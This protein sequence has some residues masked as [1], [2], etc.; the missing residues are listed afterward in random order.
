MTKGN[1]KLQ[2]LQVFSGIAILCVVLI[3]NNAYYLLG[4]LKVQAYV[5]GSFIVRLL[6][7]FIHAS[8]SMF[9]FIAGYKYALNNVNDEYKKYAIKKIK[10]V[11]K[12]FIIISMIFI[13][14]NNTGSHI[15][16]INLRNMF[17]QFIDIFMGS[18]YAYQLWYV[19]MYI[20]I[21]LTYPI[22]YKLF[23]KERSRILIILLIVLVE[24]ILG[25]KFSSLSARPFN[26]V[27]YYI[28]FE[29]G[30]I[31]YK[32]DI[33]NKIVKWDIQIICAHIIAAVILTINPIPNLYDLIQYY[34]EWPLCV[35]AYYLLSFRLINNKMFNYLGKYSFYIFLFHAPVICGRISDIFY[36]LG[37][38][39][40]IM[41]VFIITGLTI[42]CTMIVYKV[43]EHTFLKNILF[44]F[45]KKKNYQLQRPETDYNE[46]I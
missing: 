18:N 2:E 4:V 14:I 21:S 6:D 41:Y 46:V 39:N 38:Y 33:K 7:N 19:P 45:D 25:R 23:R 22:I 15:Y 28:F 13:I 11:I 26:F 20:F 29:M 40:S 30:L 9:I 12:P 43:I 16:L 35:T 44:T 10:R 36:D 27:Y 1:D 31:F 24:E 8:V 3:H 17:K 34:F 32:H 5:E 37:I 42:V